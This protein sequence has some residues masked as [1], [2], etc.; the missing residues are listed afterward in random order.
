MGLFV[1]V[2][3]SQGSLKK[4]KIKKHVKTMVCVLH[5]LRL[6]TTL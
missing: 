1:S 5:F 6:W 2:A 4:Y 3:L